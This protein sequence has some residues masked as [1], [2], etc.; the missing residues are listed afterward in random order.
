MRDLVALAGPESRALWE[1]LKLGYTESQGHPQLRQEIAELYAGRSP[2]DVM[3][4][5][6]E[7]AIFLLMNALLKAGDHVVATFPGYQSLYAVAESIG[8]Q[9][10][11]WEPDEAAGWSFDLNRLEDLVRPNTRLIVVNFPHNPTGSLLSRNDFQALV[12]L[13]RA[14][15]LHLFSDEMYRY[16]ELADDATLP[17]ACEVYER[18]FSLFG[19][20][21]T[22]GLP[23][24]RIGWMVSTDREILER[25]VELKDYTTICSSAPSEILAL[26][27]L[28]NRVE[29]ITHQ[30][31]RLKENLQVL[32][33]FMERHATIFRWNRPMGGSICFPRMLQV[34]GTQDFCDQMVVES[35]IMLVPS[36]VFQYGDRHVRIGFGR[37]N[38]ITVLG[39]F[40]EYL[41]LY[42]GVRA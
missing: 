38:F 2:A 13:V 40:S 14:R 28:Q 18:S 9:V 16:L 10:S 5:A 7:E 27:A 26:I 23:G 29:I 35:G 11:K 30:T 25:M 31:N 32:D 33:R 20:S 1:G 22:F 36:G 19:M 4:C 8:C 41:D 17:S 42:F 15:G 3:V 39:L 37:E 34:E 21:K 24:L 12:D 6:P